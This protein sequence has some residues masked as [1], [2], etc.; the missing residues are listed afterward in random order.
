MVNLL[1]I[2]LCHP[3]YHL[4]FQYQLILNDENQHNVQNKDLNIINFC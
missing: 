1:K 3:T 2:N 4:S